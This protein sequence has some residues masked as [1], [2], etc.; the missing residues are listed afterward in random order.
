MRIFLSDG[1]LLI[2]SCWETY[3]LEKWRWESDSTIVWREDTAEI[4]ASVVEL[5]PSDLVLRLKLTGGNQVQHFQI[6]SV[7]YLCQDMKR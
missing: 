5:G 7:P 3:R 1:T 2:D 6:A 4:V